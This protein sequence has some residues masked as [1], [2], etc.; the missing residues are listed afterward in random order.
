MALCLREPINITQ[1][2]LSKPPS[3]GFL[4]EENSM[5]ETTLEALRH[6]WALDDLAAEAIS[7]GIEGHQNYATELENIYGPLDIR[8]VQQRDSNRAEIGNIFTGQ[9]DKKLIIVGP[10][11]LDVDIDYTELFD[12]IDELQS[13]HRDSVIAFRGNWA[14]PRTSTGWTGLFYSLNEHSR[15]SGFDTIKEA[16]DRGI[17][18]VTEV[19][20]SVQLGSLAPYLS[21]VWIGARDIEPTERR[22]T[23]A[24]FHLPVG[25]KNSTRGSDN[26]L[27]ADT[28]K[29]I[30]SNS[31]DNKNS[32]VH[33]G[34]LAMTASSPGIPTGIIPVG[35]GNHRL[36]IIARGYT[37]PDDMSPEA[38]EEAALEHL[39]ELCELGKQE[40]T[41]VLIDG[42]HGVPPMFNIDRKHPDRFL[43]VLDKIH[44]SVTHGKVRNAE[45]LAGVMGE[46]GIV[47]G[48]TD[49]NLVL[50]TRKEPL[51]RLI[52]M[53]LASL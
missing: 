37:L 4:Y 5:T 18:V 25:I 16:F 49:I 7:M 46:V 21:G 38:K 34:Q 50:S 53:T 14:K 1:Q 17:P 22:G 43:G 23:M 30:R 47:E 32:G 27:L 10:C 40:G 35:E 44:Q 42:T 28:L 15:H 26:V 52:R 24:A 36:A 2:V 51:R 19:T 31:V 41:A 20:E 12:F 39:S 8:A 33:I 45:M 29:A 48:Q 6:H 13:E 3:G 11:S 9:S